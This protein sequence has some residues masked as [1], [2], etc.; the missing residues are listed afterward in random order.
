MAQN[1]DEQKLT[2]AINVFI[3]SSFLIVMLTVHARRFISYMYLWQC[4]ENMGYAHAFAC[5]S[6]VI[7]I[8]TPFWVATGCV[9]AW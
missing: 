2:N 8:T 5:A 4:N 7:D 9:Q 6:V 3:L 1:F